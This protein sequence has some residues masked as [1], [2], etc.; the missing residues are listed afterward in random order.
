MK[1]LSQYRKKV[2]LSFLLFTIA[3]TVLLF[4]GCE[5]P[6]EISVSSAKLFEVQLSGCDG[7]GKAE[8]VLNQDN[9]N[10]ELSRHK[11]NPH[12]ADIATLLNGMTFRLADESQQGTLTNGKDFT[13]IADYDEALAANI[14]VKMKDTEL[15]CTARNLTQG[16]PLDAFQNFKVTFSGEN[17]K[18][19]I[20]M[21][22]SKCSKNTKAWITFKPDKNEK[23]K[24]GDKVT[25]RA[26]SNVKLEEEGFYLKEEFKVFTVQ[27]LLG[28]RNSLDGIDTQAL[29]EEMHK[30]MKTKILNS[31]YITDYDYQFTSGKNRKLNSE[32]FDYESRYDL[33]SYQYIYNPDDLNKNSLIA[34]Y[35]VQTDFVCKAGQAGLPSGFTPMSGGETDTGITYMAIRTNPLRIGKNNQLDEHNDIYFD[36]E[37]GKTI[38]DL[39]KKIGMSKY[40]SEYFDKDFYLVQKTDPQSE[41]TENATENNTDT[42]EE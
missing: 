39:Q 4:S 34:Y 23:L 40:C 26:E 20:T 1:F 8:F 25:V 36:T 11:E 14:N 22:S 3:A 38:A 16:Q 27:N 18:G 10:T 6:T 21:D 9:V 42:V 41:A 32:Y 33:D 24:N 29:R 12:Y 30:E 5:K 35:K 19:E 7:H 2:C 17:G 28:P 37:N 15:I 31:Y 13:V